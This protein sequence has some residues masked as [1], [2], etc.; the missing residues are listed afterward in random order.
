MKILYETKQCFQLRV[1]KM[2]L[3]LAVCMVIRVDMVIIFLV[4]KILFVTKFTIEHLFQIFQALLDCFFL[5][6]LI[7]WK[8]TKVFCQCP[9]TDFKQYINQHIK[10]VVH[11]SGNYFLSILSLHCLFFVDPKKCYSWVI[12][13]GKL[14]LIF[15]LQFFI[16]FFLNLQN[17][18]V[19]S[20]FIRLLKLTRK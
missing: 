1:I 19:A 9:L 20:S 17:F 3:N 4:F 16:I 10:M 15:Q 8:Q 14:N 13:K 18:P 2:S 11:L 5:L 12:Q 6:L 7:L